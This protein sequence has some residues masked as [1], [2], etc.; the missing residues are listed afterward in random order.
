MILGLVEELAK[1]KT[2]SA[3]VGGIGQLTCPEGAEI[4][5]ISSGWYKRPSGISGDRLPKV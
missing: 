3:I 4:S 5:A 2:S 1:I